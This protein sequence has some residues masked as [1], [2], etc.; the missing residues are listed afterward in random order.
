MHCLP[1]GP[2]GGVGSFCLRS[3][4]FHQQILISQFNAH[5]HSHSQIRQ[6]IDRR[7]EG[8]RTRALD[9]NKA[10]SKNV[11][12]FYL[13]L[14]AKKYSFS[15][16]RSMIKE[17]RLNLRSSQRI[18]SKTST[19][20]LLNNESVLLQCNHLDP[21]QKIDVKKDNP[22]KPNLNYVSYILSNDLT[23][24]F[25]QRQDWSVYSR[26]LVFQYKDINIVG[27][28]KYMLFVNL[29][30]ML[31]HARFVYVR[32]TLLSVNLDEEESCVQ[33]RWSIIGLGML[34]FCLRYFPDRLWEKNSMER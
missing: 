10:L 2:V 22:K 14:G 12:N 7:Q 15:E 11:H 32:M 23:N 24:I 19:G 9:S 29:L 33:V 25:M 20:K 1:R 26:D 5:S 28:E 27:L 18:E 16:R 17:R 6:P 31:A 34:E 30:R 8:D 3:K 13:P 4:V 21:N